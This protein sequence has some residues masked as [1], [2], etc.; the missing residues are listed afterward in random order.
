[1][2]FGPRSALAGCVDA[3][4]Q[5]VG[6]PVT[7]SGQPDGLLVRPRASPGERFQ[8]SIS[9]EALGARVTLGAEPLS[10]A[11]SQSLS[12]QFEEDELAH[13][14]ET[15]AATVDGVH[16]FRIE[17]STV[18]V[19]VSLRPGGSSDGDDLSRL[20]ELLVVL[21]GVA[22]RPYERTDFPEYFL[23]A[24]RRPR[25]D[26]AA[27]EVEQSYDPQLQRESTNEH[28]ETENAVIARLLDLGLRPFDGSVDI[29][30]DLG[31]RAHGGGFWVCEVKSTAWSEQEQFRLGLGQ[32]VEYRHRLTEATSQQWRAMLVLSR[33]C[34]GFENRGIAASVGV[35]LV[36]GP[37]FEL[38]DEA[39]QWS[40]RA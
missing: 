37:P 17:R 12:E 28:R 39:T 27:E 31:W 29:Q 11:Y 25:I 40:D 21:L 1:M 8:L 35:T 34:V 6:V 10:A 26:I 38:P 3:A 15:L 36:D 14:Q 16:A 18:N 19:V 23:P 4:T 13:L 2:A 24:R 9:I 32:V 7:T 5:R 33:P 22:A 20:E 30:F